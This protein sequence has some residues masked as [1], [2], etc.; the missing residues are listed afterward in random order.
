MGAPP[1]E[2]TSEWLAEEVEDADTLAVQ[3]RFVSI[4]P[5]QYDLTAD[6][7][8]EQLRGWNLKP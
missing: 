3:Q 1:R 2:L 6:G 7:V 4:A 8:L 5:V